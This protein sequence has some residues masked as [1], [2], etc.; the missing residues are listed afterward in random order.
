M[1][2]ILKINK[3]W[4]EFAD[5]VDVEFNLIDP[6]TF[7]L[8]FTKKF[9]GKIFNFKKRYAIAFLASLTPN[10]IE[11]ELKFTFDEFKRYFGTDVIKLS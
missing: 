3:D 10:I 7:T 9:G 1:I 11:S 6:T 5:T 8:V 4:F 2:G